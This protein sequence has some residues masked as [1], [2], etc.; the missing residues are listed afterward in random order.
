MRLYMTIIMLKNYL[1]NFT[2]V[3]L[4]D[5]SAPP[6]SR[7]ERAQSTGEVRRASPRAVAA[8][9]TQKAGFQVASTQLILIHNQTLKKPGGYRVLGSTS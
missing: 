8:R 7:H 3:I 4:F 9:K 1:V 2:S 6:Q 5:A